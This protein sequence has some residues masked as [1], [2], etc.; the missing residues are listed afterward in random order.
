Y[1]HAGLLALQHLDDVVLELRWV[2][3]AGSGATR[4]SWGDPM[5]PW[6]AVA[7]RGARAG[8]LSRNPRRALSVSRALLGGVLPMNKTL[9]LTTLT[10]LCALVPSLGLAATSKHADKRE[11]AAIKADC[12]AQA[13]EKHFGIHFIKRNRFVNE[14]MR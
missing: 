12:K 3:V 10:L 4:C 2:E 7:P 11:T 13:K 9:R 8:S 6:W 5:L 1:R 14:C